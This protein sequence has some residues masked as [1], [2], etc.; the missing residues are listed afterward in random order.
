[1]ILR[2]WGTV[3]VFLSFRQTAEKNIARSHFY[4]FLTPAFFCALVVASE[5]RKL[6]IMGLKKTQKDENKKGGGM[7]EGD[8]IMMWP[9]TCTYSTYVII[10]TD[11][12]LSFRYI[13]GN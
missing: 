12:A 6:R 4:Y 2:K 13:L 10:S 5:R 8:A 3:I 9:L 11:P 1:M 7:E